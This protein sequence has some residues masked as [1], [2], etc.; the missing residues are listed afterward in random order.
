MVVLAAE[1]G[2]P[3]AMRTASGIPFSSVEGLCVMCNF[4]AYPVRYAS[5]ERLFDRGASTIRSI[6]S[7]VMTFL[8]HKFRV[9]IT[10]LDFVRITPDR[11]Q[12]LA[13]AVDAKGAM[14]KGVFGFID[15]TVVPAC[16]RAPYSAYFVSSLDCTDW[17]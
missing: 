11:L 4:L 14:L 3:N 10:E 6:N 15:G 9:L 7:T 17:Q 12:V 13:D 2:L 1:L 16:R 8:M 5:M